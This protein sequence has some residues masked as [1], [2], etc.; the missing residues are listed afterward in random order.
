MIPD[1]AKVLPEFKPTVA[2]NRITL[3]GRRPA[4]GGD[5]RLVHSAT[6]R[7]AAARTQC[8]NNCKQIVL[9]FH[10]YH[11]Q[12]RQLSA[13]ILSHSKDGKPL[14]SWRVLILPFLDQQALYDQFH[15]DEPWDSP[16]NRTLIAKMPAIFRCPAEK[17]RPRPGRQ[18]ALPR[19][20]GRRHDHARRRARQAPRHHRRHFQHDHRARCRRRPRGRLDQA[21]RLGIRPR[22]GG[23]RASSG[24]TS[25]AAPTWCLQTA[26]VR[27]IS[28]TIAAA[29]L[30]ALLDAQRR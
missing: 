20:A 21:R 23:S 15:L 29:T 12:A 18:D 14:L 8:V 16:H 25:P 11:Q 22:A 13:R 4:G 10:N 9:A 6:G 1:L 19:A 24:A 26:A 17:R 3:A 30:R 2:E 28:A 5:L 27:F 7:R